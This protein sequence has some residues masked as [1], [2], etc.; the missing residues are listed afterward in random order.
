M[1][2]KGRV[3]PLASRLMKLLAVAI[4]EHLFEQSIRQDI[5]AELGLREPKSHTCS[6]KLRQRLS[7]TMYKPSFI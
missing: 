4:F 5:L 1:P 7:V 6:L 2:A 3:C